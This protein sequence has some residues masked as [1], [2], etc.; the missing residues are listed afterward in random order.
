MVAAKSRAIICTVGRALDIPPSIVELVFRLAIEGSLAYILF[1]GLKKFTLGGL[2]ELSMKP[3]PSRAA[4]LGVH[5]F[6]KEGP[7]LLKAKRAWY[8]VKLK[9][10]KKFTELVND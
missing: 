1:L 8:T 9:L 6:T 7:I 10:T 5:P 2:L 3:Y 4:K